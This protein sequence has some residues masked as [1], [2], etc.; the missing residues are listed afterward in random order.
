MRKLE[1]ICHLECGAGWYGLLNELHE[2]IERI[3]P[4]YTVSQVKEKFSSLRYYITLPKDVTPEDAKEIYR[5]IDKAERKSETI[6]ET[7]GNPGKYCDFGWMKTLC[8]NC[9]RKVLD[10]K[11]TQ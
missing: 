5:L 4:G 9:L 1:D 8:D 7:C 11:E 3:A 6:C 10:R 2:S